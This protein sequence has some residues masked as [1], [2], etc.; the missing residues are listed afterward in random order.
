VAS[1]PSPQ[2]SGWQRAPRTPPPSP[3]TSGVQQGGADGGGYRRNLRVSGRGRQD[4]WRQGTSRVLRHHRVDVPR[5]AV[6]ER[7]VVHRRLDTCRGRSRRRC[8]CPWRRW[9]RRRWW[10]CE[11]RRRQPA[12]VDAHRLGEAG[13][14]GRYRRP[15]RRCCPTTPARPGGDRRRGPRKGDTTVSDTTRPGQGT[16]LVGP[17]G[18]ERVPVERGRIGGSTTA[19]VRKRV[20]RSRSGSEEGGVVVEE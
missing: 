12:L 20:K 6:K 11:P 2:Q 8:R 17:A 4:S 16:G 18:G 7:W 5:V 3:D 19:S 10:R 9:W 13:Q 1:S 14:R 15:R